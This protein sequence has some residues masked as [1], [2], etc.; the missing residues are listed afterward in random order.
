VDKLK[1]NQLNSNREILR[2]I[3]HRSIE[4]NRIKATNERKV[5]AHLASQD[6]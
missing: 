5:E 3:R 2:K 6:V 1:K 4:K